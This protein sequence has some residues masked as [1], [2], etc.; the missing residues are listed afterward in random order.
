MRLIANILNHDD[1]VEFSYFL[2]KEGIRNHL[3]ESNG[4]GSLLWIIQEDQVASALEWYNEFKKDTK[5]PLFRG[6]KKLAINEIQDLKKKEEA[7]KIIHSKKQANEKKASVSTFF[8]IVC[9]LLFFSRFMVPSALEK[10]N[11]T[12]NIPIIFS[13]P[14]YESLMFDFPKYFQ[15]MKIIIFQYSTQNS[16]NQEEIKILE[17]KALNTPYWDGFYDEL[18]LY[19]QG[20]GDEIHFNAPLFEQIRKGEVWRAFT[21]CLL[22]ADIFHIF[23]NMFWLLVLGPPIEKNIGKGRFILFILIAGILSNFT[24]YFVSGPNF[25]GFSGVVAALLGF[26]WMRQKMYPWED[27]HTH[28][29]VFL[30]LTLGIFLMVFLQLI[31]F[32]LELKGQAPIAAGI[33]NTAHLSGLIIGLCVGRFKCMS[34]KSG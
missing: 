12:E 2:T 33:A 17:K 32:Y 31:S 7:P 24:Q 5:N 18:L 22:H 11:T 8:L 34:V 29:G 28:Q 26:T 23:F 15:L 6:Y 20:N 14:V 9:A 21:P 19:L 13:S 16:P 4:N 30:I 3:D 27:Y 1:A 10:Q 25:L